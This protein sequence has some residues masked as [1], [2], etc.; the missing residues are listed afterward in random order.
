[1]TATRA[2]LAQRRAHLLLQIADER[3]MISQAM[4]VWRQPLAL[5]DLA[6]SVAHFVRLHPIAVACAYGALR[7]VLPRPLTRISHWWR[8]G[9]LLALVLRRK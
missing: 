6:R 5:L 4:H 8:S 9:R 1:M 7:L 3:R 2:S